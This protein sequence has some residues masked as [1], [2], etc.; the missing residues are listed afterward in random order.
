[1]MH[2]ARPLPITLQKGECGA[3]DITGDSECRGYG[4]DKMG[5]AGSQRALKADNS[6]LL[7]ERKKVEGKGRRFPSGADHA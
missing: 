7:Q 5:F 6:R 3:G 2:P 1:M 4:F